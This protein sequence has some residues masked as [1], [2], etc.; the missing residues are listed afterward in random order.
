MT[1]LLST[2]IGLAAEVSASCCP[3]LPRRS[4]G[5]FLT[6]GGR[7]GNDLA[8]PRKNPR[9][10]VADAVG[11]RHSAHKPPERGGMG[12]ALCV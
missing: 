8:V 9:A 5:V 3:R 2:V 7:S 1:H 6:I 4:A 10:A 12:P 11:A